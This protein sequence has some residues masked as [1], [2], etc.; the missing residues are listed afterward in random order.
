MLKYF[1]KFLI[2]AILVT[3]LFQRG[4]IDIEYVKEIISNTQILGLC[5]L[6]FLFQAILSS[7]RFLFILKSSHIH[8]ISFFKAL[9]LNQ[10]GLFF[11]TFLPGS[12]SG[13]F[14]K[15]YYLKDHAETDYQKSIILSLSDRII[16][17]A[18]LLLYSRSSYPRK[19]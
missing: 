11:N 7:L 8:S 18:G 2:S 3:W 13:D 5:L 15:A 19:V 17:L 16:G 9:C 14:F 10:V 1:I 6:I 12:V 4:L